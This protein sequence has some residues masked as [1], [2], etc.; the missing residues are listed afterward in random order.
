MTHY[1]LFILTNEY[2][3]HILP[4]K[5]TLQLNKARPLTVDH[6]QEYAEKLANWHE[7]VTPQIHID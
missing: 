2:T 4:Y 3:L 1:F 7:L 5:L 6:H